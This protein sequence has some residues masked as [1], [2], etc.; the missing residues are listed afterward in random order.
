MGA[1]WA[2]IR[3]TQIRAEIE[4]RFYTE[5]KASW[6]LQK[7]CQKVVAWARFDRV[8][9][10][11]KR[12]IV[13]VQIVQRQRLAANVIGW[14]YQRR[15]QKLTLYD[16]FQKRRI[17]LDEYERLD[18]LKIA[19][20]VDR[21]EALEQKRITDENLK[22]TIDSSW[23]QGSDV[24]GRN[25]FYNYVTG[26]TQWEP[27]ETWKAPVKDTWLRQTDPERGS[28]YYYNMFTGESSWLPPCT[29][30]GE[31]GERYCGNCKV[32][33][34]ERCHERLHG[35]EAGKFM[36]SPTLLA[37]GYIS[38]LTYWWRLVSYGVVH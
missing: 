1:S 29:E 26:E 15:N 5:R 8:A 16:R 25:Y 2:F 37:K 12:V 14:Y 10:Y 4:R 27:P 20:Y 13:E 34:C 9:A 22:A 7:F 23:K 3:K 31:L 30:C 21:D 33:Y 17:M 18:K 35:D 36:S 19:A 28:I 38:I 6:K 32:A 11:R 24:T